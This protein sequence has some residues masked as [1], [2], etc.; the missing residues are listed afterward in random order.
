MP[1]INRAVELRFG[2]G[3]CP[4]PWPIPAHPA[5]APCN[6]PFPPPRAGKPELKAHLQKLAAKPYSERLADFHLLLY[7]ARQPNFDLSGECGG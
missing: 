4:C 7:L 3:A 6:T 1:F 5:P 2:E